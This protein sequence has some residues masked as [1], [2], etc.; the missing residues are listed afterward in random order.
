VGHAD[1]KEQQAR[2]LARQL[3]RDG[4]R[5]ASVKYAPPVTEGEIVLGRRSAD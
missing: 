3:G 2:S 1:K 5:G 4:N